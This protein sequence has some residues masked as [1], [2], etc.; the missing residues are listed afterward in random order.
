MK[1]GKTGK[2]VLPGQPGESELIHR[3]LLPKEDED[4]MPP[5]EKTQLTQNEVALLH[6]WIST[7]ADFSK[8][9]KELP[10][11]EKIKPILLALQQGTAPEGEKQAAELTR[12]EVTKEDETLI[13]KLQDAGVPV[14]PVGLN[15][16]YLSANFVNAAA[17]DS[18]VEL[19]AS[20]QKQLIWLNLGNTS[21][22][23]AGMPVL[24]K[25]GNLRKLNLNNTDITDKGL[26]ALKSATHLQY[27]NLV[28]T[29]VSVNGVLALKNL[30]ALKSIYLYQTH[31]KGSDWAALKKAFP[32]A[33][34]DSGGYTVPTLAK[35]T[36]E[37]T[38]PVK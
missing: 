28:G 17:P 5:K 30:A 29:K 6:W 24:S 15:S 21:L 36:S 19:L 34:L 11:T 4:H 7:G 2:A 26:A 18:T 12:E 37:V 38:A 33:V 3:L 31:V 13:K 22:T 14:V 16:N 35:D 8:K 1:G 20:L 10:Q 9:T 27:L 23:D 25:L 32:G